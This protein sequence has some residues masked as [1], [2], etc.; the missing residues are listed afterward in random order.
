M[1]IISAWWMLDSLSSTA[2]LYIRYN[3]VRNSKDNQSTREREGDVRTGV[4]EKIE[5]KV[6][7]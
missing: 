5:N 6:N 3:E 2:N 1:L 4:Y 7:I